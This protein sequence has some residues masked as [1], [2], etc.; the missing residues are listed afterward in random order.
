MR[1]GGTYF[2]LHFK[3]K[4]LFSGKVFTYPSAAAVS[5]GAVVGAAAVV[6]AVAETPCDYYPGH[7]PAAP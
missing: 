3:T 6:N 4:S 7:R 2:L 5:T 1:K